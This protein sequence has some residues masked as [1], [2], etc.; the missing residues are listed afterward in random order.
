MLRVIF[1]YALVAGFPARAHEATIVALLGHLVGAADLLVWGE[2]V[3]GPCPRSPQ[4]G[5]F[6]RDGDTTTISRCE[7]ANR[8]FWKVGFR[9]GTAGRHFSNFLSA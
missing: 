6:K 2:P 5:S 3:A 7:T 1:G 9:T 4:S 8:A